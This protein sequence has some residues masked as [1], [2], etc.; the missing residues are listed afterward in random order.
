LP[1]RALTDA[2]VRRLKAPTDGQVDI[3]DQGYPGLALRLS[4]GG[5]RTFVYFYR[6]GGKLRRMS[7]GT[8]PA[9]SLAEAREAWR[10]AREDVAKGRDPAIDLKR[11]RAA[12]DFKN[13]SDEW[14]RRDQAKNRSRSTVERILNKDVVPA[15]GHRNIADI[16][17]RDCLDLIDGIVDRGA[18]SMARQVHAHLHRLFRWCVGRGIIESNPMADLPKSGEATKRERVLSDEELK[19]VWKAAKEV[20]W[21]F[22]SV[23]QLLILTGARRS[24]VA[25]LRRPE[26]NGAIIDLAGERTK[27]GEPHTIPLSKPALAIIADLPRIADSDL[28]FTTNGKSPI[29]GWSKAKSELDEKLAEDKAARSKLSAWVLHDIRRSVATGLQRLGISLQVIEAVLGHTSGSRSGV[30]GVYQRHSFAAEKAAALE[31]W[32]AHVMALV[33]GKKPG[34]VIAMRKGNR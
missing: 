11:P 19:A 17:R 33:E 10:G 29:S 26:I 3:F 34:K 23:V 31:A 2:T 24:E 4:H 6:H 27:N 13:V 28:V 12:S 30:V 14:L 5:R 7:L 8:F 18:V 9:I 25:Q 22:G 16:G 21:P 20:G 1:K 32:G 15:W